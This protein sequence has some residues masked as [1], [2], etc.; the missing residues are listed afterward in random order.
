METITSELHIQRDLN[1]NPLASLYFHFKPEEELL[2]Y[3]ESWNNKWNGPLN[4]F[5]IFSKQSFISKDWTE[6]Q[7][8]IYQLR[9]YYRDITDAFKAH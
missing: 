3:I 4:I 8:S 2:V 7:E 6:V 9:K 1:A 5:R